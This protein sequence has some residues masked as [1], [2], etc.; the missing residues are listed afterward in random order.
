ML[1]SVKSFLS[2]SI[3]AFSIDNNPLLGFTFPPVNIET[4]SN[5][6]DYSKFY[7]TLN[8]GLLTKLLGI[9]ELRQKAA[10][11]VDGNVLEFGLI[12]NCIKNKTSFLKKVQR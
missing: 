11:F 4:R 1:L 6:N 5:Y 7:N 12:F 8:G 3:I 9:E 10:S 2:A